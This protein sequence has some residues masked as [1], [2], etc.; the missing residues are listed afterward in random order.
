MKEHCTLMGVVVEKV[1]SAK[2]GLSEA[3][4]SLM[5]GFEVSDVML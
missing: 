3:F 5:T 4:T 1:Q 2:S